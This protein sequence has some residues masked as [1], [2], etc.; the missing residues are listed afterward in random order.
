MI[1]NVLPPFLWFTVYNTFQ[2]NGKHLLT[3]THDAKKGNSILYLTKYK[4]WTQR[5]P[6]NF[7]N[8]NQ[9]TQCAITDTTEKRKQL[10][11]NKVKS[12]IFKFIT[13]LYLHRLH[14]IVYSTN[15]LLTQRYS[16]IMWDFDFPAI[17][18]GKY[19]Y[20]WI[21][22]LCKQSIVPQEIIM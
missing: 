18:T 1:T 22:R 8:I 4:F 7:T 10:N 3:F 5:V 21:Y 19:H 11:I 16:N 14:K 2:A 15:I 17:Q 9:N 13:T 20:K 6:K 12:V